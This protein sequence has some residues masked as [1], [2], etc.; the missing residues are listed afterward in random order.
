MSSSSEQVAN[1][2]TVRLGS[3]ETREECLVVEAITRTYPSFRKIAA[4]LTEQEVQIG[5]FHGNKDY[6]E[7]QA[8][9]A[10]CLASVTV[11]NV[12]NDDLNGLHA[13]ASFP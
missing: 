11:R 5:N 9:C 12:F 8:R 2:G 4:S 7:W 13:T 1:T 6:L 3:G 10:K